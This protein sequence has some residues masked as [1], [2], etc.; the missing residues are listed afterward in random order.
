MKQK[1]KIELDNHSYIWVLEGN[2]IYS[3]NKWIIVILQGTSY[4]RLYINPYAYE[5][6]IKP[7]YIEKAIKYARNNGWLPE[8]NNGEM[9]LSFN[10]EEFQIIKSA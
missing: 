1:R 3:E 7:S 6:E 8:N 4:S 9:R 2:E 5:F 10:N